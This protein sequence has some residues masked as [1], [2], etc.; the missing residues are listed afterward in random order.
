MVLGGLVLVQ[1][2]SPIEVGTGLPSQ[3]SRSSE[4]GG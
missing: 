2:L 3:W 1:I 4:G